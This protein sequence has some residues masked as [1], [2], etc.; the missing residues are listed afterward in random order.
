MERQSQ[1]FSLNYLNICLKLLLINIMTQAFFSSKFD[2]LHSL[3][4]DKCRIQNE[5]CIQNTEHRMNEEYT[6]VCDH[7]SMLNLSLNMGHFLIF[8]S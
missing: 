6:P 3:E 1:G 2:F 8:Y 5:E 7:L 4:L